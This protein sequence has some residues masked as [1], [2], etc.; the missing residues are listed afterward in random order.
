MSKSLPPVCPKCG[1]IHGVF[2]A[3]DPHSFAY[4]RKWVKSQRE[5]RRVLEEATKLFPDLRALAEELGVFGKRR[6]R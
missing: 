3:E 4:R 1:N 6:K 2:I 5:S